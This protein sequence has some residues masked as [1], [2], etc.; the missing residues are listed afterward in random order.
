MVIHNMGHVGC[1]PGY[2]S[3]TGRILDL[4]GCLRQYLWENMAAAI[5]DT[6]EVVFERDMLQ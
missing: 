6:R 1:R 2:V 5:L 4:L 3:T